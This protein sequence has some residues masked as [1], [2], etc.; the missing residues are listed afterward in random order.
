MR[1][2]LLAV[3][4][5]GSLTF[6]AQEAQAQTLSLSLDTDA[7]QA[8]IKTNVG[9]TYH[10]SGPFSMED[11]MVTSIR[12]GKVYGTFDLLF[13]GAISIP[14][15]FYGKKTISLS[16]TISM[17]YSFVPAI[18]KGVLRIPVKSISVSGGG[19]SLSLGSKVLG[20]M[21]DFKR[22]LFSTRGQSLLDKT[23]R[24]DFI[25]LL[26]RY[27]GKKKWTISIF[28]GTNQV[29]VKGVAVRAPETGLRATESGQR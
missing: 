25:T 10:L 22:F 3:V 19:L 7:V 27:L 15:P 11:L 4:V 28:L 21:V 6:R 29:T 9:G 5:L 14:I 1:H 12:N 16:K 13:D 2:I 26:R 20:I 24:L 8:L 23:I 18:H 17:K